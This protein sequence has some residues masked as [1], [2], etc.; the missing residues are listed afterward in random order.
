MAFNIKGITVK[1]NG[2]TSDLTKKLNQVK[3]ETMGLDSTMRKLQSSMRKVDGG[4]F[5]SFATNQELL[6]EKMKSLNRQLELQKNAYSNLDK[7]TSN[8]KQKSLALS[9][10][11]A[12]LEN[13]LKY[14]GKSFITTN[15]TALK[16]IYGL[17]NVSSKMAKVSE[18]T[19]TISLLSGGALVGATMATI[20][21]EDAW[22]GVTKTVEGTP[23]QMQAINQGLKDLATSTSS[24]YQNIAHFAELAGQ[25]GIATK[26]T[27]GFTE[28]IVKLNDTTNLLGDE[29]AQSIAKFANI[30][31]SK[32]EQT[33]SYFS[34]LGSTIVDLGNNFATTESDIMLMSMRLATAGKQVGFSSQEVLALSTALSSL[35]IEAQAGGGSISKM[36]KTIQLAV[37]TGSADLELF[38]QTAGMSAQEFQKAWGEDAAQAF[39]K[40]VQGIGKSKDVTKTLNDLGIKEIRLSN[41]MGAL[42]QNS[43]LLSSALSVS[44]NAWKENTAMTEEA[45]KRYSTLK[46][47]LSQAWEAIKQVGDELG[48]SLAPTVKNVAEGI[49]TFAKSFSKLSDG[50]KST[51]ANLLLFGTAISPVS[52]GLSKMSKGLSSVLRISAKSDEAF[53]TLGKGFDVVKSSIKSGEN[54][55]ATLGSKIM[56]TSVSVKLLTGALTLGAVAIMNMKKANDELMKSVEDEMMANNANYAVAKQVIDGYKEYSDTVKGLTKANDDLKTGLQL[57]KMESSGL[58]TI[59]EDLNRRENL[60]VAQKTQLAK[61]V[62]R[63]NKLYPELNLQ[64]DENT[65]KLKLSGD[66]RYKDIQAIKEHVK[67]LQQEAE[68]EAVKKMVSNNAEALAETTLEYQNQKQAVQDLSAE[69]KKLNEAFIEGGGSD[70]ALQAKLQD[71]G[72]KLKVLQEQYSNTTQ[73]MI[74]LQAQQSLY[75][76]YLETKDYSTIGT[77]LTQQLQSMVQSASDAGWK[78]PSNLASALQDPTSIGS[79]QTACNL[80]SSVTN[81]QSLIDKSGMVGS[82]IP[83]KIANEMIANAPTLS[84]AIDVMNNLIKFVNMVNSANQ[85]GKQITVGVAKGMA[86]ESGFVGQEAEK[87]AQS[88]VDK[89]G[90]KSKDM[91]I[92]ARSTTKDIAK[93]FNSSTVPNAAGNMGQKAY[94][95]FSGYLNSMVSDSANARDKIKANIKSAQD[96]ANAHPVTITE[97]KKPK[98]KKNIEAPSS[99]MGFMAY[100]LPRAP[101]PQ[102]VQTTVMADY[103]MRSPKPSTSNNGISVLSNKID[104][105]ITT[106]TDMQL[107]IQ[108]QPQELDGEAITDSVT[109][110]IKIRELLSNLGKGL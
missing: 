65:G 85:Q 42:A 34:R 82:V 51:I 39:L 36:L 43:D 97:Q 22:A 52:W 16:L 60:S 10:N 59:I 23:E 44:S 40:F 100:D 64:I 1:I 87:L 24:S 48:Q 21:F 50:T 11:I 110:I 15:Q 98:G 57:N 49:K 6:S 54:V 38:A 2:D 14:L 28:T 41:A 56:S 107:N 74:E 92:K 63:L 86:E 84:S 94:T 12:Q 93:E 72:E 91:A 25:M 9:A 3:A 80:L 108:L 102:E 33:N 4:N 45:N 83:S 73:K 55:F 18:A 47:S 53:R 61:S 78:I 7:S 46:S 58:I 81:F 32:G 101:I 29:A 20:S 103:V 109:E 77:G 37:S 19:K 17:D 95:E 30:M 66:A 71:Q 62:E 104:K 88:A 26:A 76:N 90:N 35:G 96:Y 67:A 75:E 79:V 89:Y 31:V 99:F 5:K 8:Y 13:E 68:V 27:V 69:Y 106:F 105:L 70:T